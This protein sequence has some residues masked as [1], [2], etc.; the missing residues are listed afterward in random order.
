MSVGKLKLAGTPDGPAANGEHEE[1]LGETYGTTAR[2]KPLLRWSRLRGS[3]ACWCLVVGRCCCGSAGPIS[4]EEA[5][6][7]GRVKTSQDPLGSKG[8]KADAG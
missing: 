6:E 1:G 4:W 8:G 7:W 3:A 5:V 2:G